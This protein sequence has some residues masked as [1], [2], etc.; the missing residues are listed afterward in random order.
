ML[1]S[2]SRL[3]S[4]LALGLLVL[5]STSRARGEQG[6]GTPSEFEQLG[7]TTREPRFARGEHAIPA[8]GH[9]QGIQLKLEAAAQRH[10]AFLSHDSLTVAYLV[11]VAFPES[12]DRPGQ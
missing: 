2:F 1:R 10:L 5:A 8:G 11:V 9:F 7:G 12:L 6:G 3:R 4:W